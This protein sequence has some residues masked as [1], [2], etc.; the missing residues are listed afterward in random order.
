MKKTY[1]KPKIIFEDFTLNDSIA[2]DCEMIT[3][4]P[5]R[6]QCGIDFGGMIIFLEDTNCT[7]VPE[8]DDYNGYCYHLPTEGNNLFNS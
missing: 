2:G 5:A 4:T 6:R 1:S 3:D 8:V 7:Y